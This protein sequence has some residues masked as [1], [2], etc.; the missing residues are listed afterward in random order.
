M[1]RAKMDRAQRAKQ[2]APFAALKGFDEALRAKERMIVPKVELTE[3]KKEEIDM[4]L[5]TKKKQDYI[6]VIYYNQENYVKASGVISDINV[7]EQTMKIVDTV[8]SFE[9]IR[10][11][12]ED[13][14]GIS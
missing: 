1:I 7:L 2:F 9:N 8:I 3:E 12:V 10:D 11:I 6:S 13:E 4:I 5:R 14:N